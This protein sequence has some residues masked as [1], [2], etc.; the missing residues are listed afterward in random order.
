MAKHS[1]SGRHILMELTGCPYDLLNSV[2]QAENTLLSCA[3]D[4]GATVISSHFHPFFPQ[5]LSGVI[6]I[7]ESHITIHT[8]P[9]YGY[10]AV[11]VFTCGVAGI[12]D[13][14][15]RLIADRFQA[16]DV[17]LKALSRTPSKTIQHKTHINL[18]EES[19]HA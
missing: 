17:K 18:I 19:A 4:G 5:G 13:E 16:K 14:V 3:E 15:G 10:A 9:E 6:V 2:V 8:W 11:D 1:P 7:A 12:A